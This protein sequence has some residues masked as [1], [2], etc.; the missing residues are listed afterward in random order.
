[1]AYQLKFSHQASKDLDELIENPSLKKHLKSVRKTL[2]HLELNPRHPS[3]HTHKYHSIQGPSGEMVFES[4][5]ENNSP[6]AY[7][8][9]WLYGPDTKSITIIAITPHP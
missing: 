1:M 5:A 7:R 2:G 8:I 9:F 4:Y 6:G 3:L